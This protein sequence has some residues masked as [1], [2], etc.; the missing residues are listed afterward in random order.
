[1]KDPKPGGFPLANLLR[2]YVEQCPKSDEEKDKMKN[3]LYASAVGSLIYTMMCTHP[4][5]AYVMGIISKFLANPGK[6]H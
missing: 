5:I 1:M 4:Y 6:E 3:V 2:L